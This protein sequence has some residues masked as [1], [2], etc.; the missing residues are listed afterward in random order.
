MPS[1]KNKFFGKDD[2]VNGMERKGHGF[3]CIIY[4]YIFWWYSFVERL[5]MG[6]DWFW[7]MVMMGRCVVTKV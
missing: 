7:M 2:D 5:I 1:I 6:L 4:I 3:I